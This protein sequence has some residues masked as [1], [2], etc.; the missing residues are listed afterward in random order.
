M[1]QSAF[2]KH[3]L[4]SSFLLLAL[5]GTLTGQVNLKNGN[6]YITYTDLTASSVDGE[7]LE[8]NR[9]Y[10]SITSDMGLFGRGWG[11]DYETYLVENSEGSLTV[12]ENGSGETRVYW[13]EDKPA[14]LE[15][16]IKQIE[17]ALDTMDWNRSRQQLTNYLNRCAEDG[18]FREDQIGF[19]QKRGLLD[20]D[21]SLP[22]DVFWNYYYGISMIIVLETGFIRLY[23]ND[24]TIIYDFFDSDGR[25]SRVG[26]RNGR[27]MNLHYDHDGHLI[28]LDMGGESG[29]QFR[30]DNNHLKSI[31]DI[32]SGNCAVYEFDGNNL[33]YCRTTSLFFRYKYDNNSNL[34]EIG[35]NDG[36]TKM[37]EYQP[38]TQFTEK[39]ITRIGDITTYKYGDNIPNIDFWTVVRYHAG[40][41]NEEMERWHYVIETSENGYTWT[42][43]LQVTREDNM[44]G[45]EKNQDGIITSLL[46]GPG[47]QRV[48]F[49]Y[50]RIG[51]LNRIQGQEI[52]IHFSFESSLL[53]SIEY[54]FFD[55]QGSL[56]Y[57]FG[58]FGLINVQL[59]DGRRFTFNY[60]EKGVLERAALNLGD[61][62]TFILYYNSD[63]ELS[64]I[65][66][67][68]GKELESFDE[69]WEAYNVEIYRTFFEFYQFHKPFAKVFWKGE[70][71]CGE[72]SLGFH[73]SPGR[74]MDLARR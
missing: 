39:I 40:T 68:Q 1:K 35:Y 31:T 66:D 42:R 37:I 49:R 33:I 13:R 27:E 71:V 44:F 48:N 60:N 25:L 3:L 56:S 62:R 55:E 12:H 43:L 34:V 16:S 61:D 29:F 73:D 46:L 15:S 11:S 22:G 6:Y 64:G 47:E 18:E 2:F 20:A 5:T 23:D 52:E 19:F 7:N 10:N 70:F 17:S 24:G 69:F 38:E 50:D 54:D 58:D 26:Y 45:V 30:Y 53:S 57:S 67:T 9:T 36:S 72:C 65:E 41:E 28:L 21:P 8:I 74:L 4:F 59:G 51:R 14:T 63:G 32:S